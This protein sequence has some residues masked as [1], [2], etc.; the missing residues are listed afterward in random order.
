MTGTIVYDVSHYD[1]SVL[2]MSV[3]AF[4][5]KVWMEWWRGGGWRRISSLVCGNHPPFDD[6]DF[7]S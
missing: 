5:K 7:K 4:P 3:V 2:S 6:F 1:L